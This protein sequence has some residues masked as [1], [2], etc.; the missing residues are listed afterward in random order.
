MIP[1]IVEAFPRKYFSLLDKYMPYFVSHL[2]YR[3]IDV[4]S[5]KE[6]CCRWYPDV[7]KNAPAKGFKHRALDDIKESIKELQ[8][9]RK[10]LFK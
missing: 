4:S 9:Y 2:H 5:I 1:N 3:I 10:H 7:F 6:L 8:Y